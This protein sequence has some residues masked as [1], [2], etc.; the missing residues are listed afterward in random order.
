[1]QRTIL[2]SLISMLSLSGC[3]GPNPGSLAWVNNTSA[4]DQKTYHES[5]CKGY[6]FVV[7]SAEMASC[8]AAESRTVAENANRTRNAII[9]GD[10]QTNLSRANKTKIMDFMPNA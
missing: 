5:V 6:G 4:A 7:G 1:M 3:G 8:I 10:Y 9:F 2:L